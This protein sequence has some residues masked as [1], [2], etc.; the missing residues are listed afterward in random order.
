MRLPGGLW[1]KKADLTNKKGENG[2]EGVAGGC[3]EKEESVQRPGVNAKM[4][5]KKLNESDNGEKKNNSRRNIASA[6]LTTGPK[7]PG[8][9]HSGKL[10]GDVETASAGQPGSTAATG[11]SRSR[12]ST[13]YVRRKKR[14]RSFLSRYTVKKQAEG[15]MGG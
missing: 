7:E 8:Y 14:R 5:Q 10:G 1:G 4:D 2:K 6:R 3:K 13:K 11:G 12:G 9:S 15:G